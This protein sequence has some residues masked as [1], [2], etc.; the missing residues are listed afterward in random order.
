MGL[1][2]DMFSHEYYVKATYQM[3]DGSVIST[4]GY[5]EAAFADADD[6]K[7]YMRRRMEVKHGKK[8]VKTL[9]FDM[10]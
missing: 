7:D 8:V 6:C 2:F 4:E 9:S 10:V 3:V 1:L 5:L